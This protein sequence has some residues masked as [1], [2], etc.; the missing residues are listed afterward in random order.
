VANVFEKYPGEVVTLEKDILD[1]TFE[2]RYVYKG[3][4]QLPEELPLLK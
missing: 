1:T 4:W 2:N 3:D